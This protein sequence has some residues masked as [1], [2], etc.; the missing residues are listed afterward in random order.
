MSKDEKKI[1]VVKRRLLIFSE[2]PRKEQT[3]SV[4][5]QR[6]LTGITF[7]SSWTL[8][9]TRYRIASLKRL[10]WT[11]LA[12]NTE[13]IFRA[14]YVIYSWFLINQLY[15]SFLGKLPSSQRTPVRPAGHKQVPSCAS[16]VFP[17]QSH[18]FAQPSPQLPGG[19]SW[20]DNQD[21]SWLCHKLV[22]K[23]T[24]CLHHTAGHKSLLYIG[25]DQ[26]YDHNHSKCYLN[27]YMF[28]NSRNQIWMADTL[29]KK[30]LDYRDNYKIKQNKWNKI[31][32]F[33]K[34]SVPDWHVEP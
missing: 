20:N 15:S 32:F 6:K 23:I 29:F 19:H 16:H 31:N 11:R 34:I 5:R 7:P 2:N 13:R 24:T 26:S 4:R 33:T 21:C 25:I 17:L 8:A 3:W 22:W 9:F 27:S 1:L 30:Q 28:V 18:R 14:I 12:T 10:T